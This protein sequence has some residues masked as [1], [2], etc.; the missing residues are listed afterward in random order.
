VRQAPAAVSVALLRSWATLVRGDGRER[1]AAC[2]ELPERPGDARADV[3]G[4]AA[5]RAPRAA[6]AGAHQ[7]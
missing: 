2:G 1:V 6:P 4:S 3:L 7:R 5:R